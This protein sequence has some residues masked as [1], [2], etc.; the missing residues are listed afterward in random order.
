MRR[1]STPSI[2]LTMDT[3]VA[4]FI[5]EL[6]ELIFE[7]TRASKTTMSSAMDTMVM[8]VTAENL[9]NFARANEFASTS[10]VSK[11]VWTM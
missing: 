8:A 11:V 1:A 2:S 4:S 9:D 10:H 3:M 6:V 7:T 5:V